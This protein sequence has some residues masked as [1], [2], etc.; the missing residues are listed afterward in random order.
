METVDIRDYEKMEKMFKHNTFFPKKQIDK[1]TFE[2][3]KDKNEIDKTLPLKRLNF[4]EDTFAYYIDTIEFNLVQKNNLIKFI[5]KYYSSMF[6]FMYENNIKNIKIN[7]V[8]SFSKTQ[9]REYTDCKFIYNPHY[10]FI[11]LIALYQIFHLNT[12]NVQHNFHLFRNNYERYAKLPKLEEAFQNKDE[13]DI[14]IFKTNFKNN[15]L[16]FDNNLI[17]NAPNPGLYYLCP[18]TKLI[19]YYK[20]LGGL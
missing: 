11:L 19:S 12:Q 1:Y 10:N 8:F 14:H 2:L 15:F 16:Y 3:T 9:N 7:A 20:T 13:F 6:Y 5:H 18:I 17:L 4:T